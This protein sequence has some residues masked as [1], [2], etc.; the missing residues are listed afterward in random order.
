M[1]NDLVTVGT[2]VLFDRIIN[3]TLY[4]VT[5]DVK[6]TLTIPIQCNNYGYKPAISFKVNLVPGS[7]CYQAVVKITN[8]AFVRDIDIRSYNVMEIEAGYRNSASMGT[9]VIK[10]FAAY[11][12]K[13]NPDGEVTF[14]GLTVGKSGVKLLSSGTHRIIVDKKEVT[15]EELIKIFASK[16]GLRYDVSHCHKEILAAKITFEPMDTSA[17]NGL[18]TLQWLQSLIYDWGQSLSLVVEQVRGTTKIPSKNIY[19]NL[20]WINDTLILISNIL[21]EDQ[22]TD[23]DVIDLRAVKSASF[24][25]PALTVRA[26][27]V[28]SMEPG[29]I[30]QMPPYYFDGSKLPNTMSEAVFNPSNNLYRCITMSIAF[31][32]TGSENEMVLMG[33]PVSNFPIDP[34]A[35]VDY[36][37]STQLQRTLQ[38]SAGR[39]EP[40]IIRIGERSEPK[41][42]DVPPNELFSYN[43]NPSNGVTESVTYINEEGKSQIRYNC[44]EDVGIKNY[45]TELWKVKLSAAD[46]AKLHDKQGVKKCYFFPLAILATYNKMQ[47]DKSAN[48]YVDKNNPDALRADKAVFIP[49]LDLDQLVRSHDT[50]IVGIFRA[51]A[52]FYYNQHKPYYA[53][54]FE[55]IA[56][57]IEKGQI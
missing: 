14:E 33:V 32:T 22:F 44:F 47:I 34:T 28:P 25:G 17:K 15:C 57:Y 50:T 6:S 16:L 9:F 39:Q 48:Y 5:G 21:T 36:V 8:A 12:S 10:I 42:E 37:M 51:T 30:F 55:D 46:K 43:Y 52:Q 38:A 31:S 4:K 29:K 54:A 27:Y 41:K 7:I 11:I 20:A 24:S 13:P 49:T 3:V 40:V 18:S 19:L 53:H 1:E 56:L 26:M 45:G 23:E 35:S 2:E